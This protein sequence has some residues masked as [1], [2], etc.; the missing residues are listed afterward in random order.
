MDPA[1]EALVPPPDTPPGVPED[2]LC[3]HCGYPSG[4]S[5]SRI[6]PEC[7]WEATPAEIAA[8]ARRDAEVEGWTRQGAP[9]TKTRWLIVVAL[10][11]LGAGV[12]GREAGPAAYA[13][14]GLS[15]VVGLS[16]WMGGWCVLRSRP[17]RG[18]Y[19]RMVWQRK[20]WI[21][22]LPWLV[23]PLFVAAAVAVGLVDLWAGDERGAAYQTVVTSGFFLW[24]LASLGCFFAWWGV[25]LRAVNAGGYRAGTADALAFFAGLAITAGTV[26][27]GFLAGV[28][29]A[30]SVAQWLHIGVFVD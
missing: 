3:T 2:H 8:F 15:M 10:Y 26:M 16:W 22:H 20:L 9:R 25:R 18:A 5:G 12:I 6:C 11:S 17:D 28:L 13:L 7:G 4:R 14:L 19:L 27:L 24:L 23:A 21:L 1:L 30:L 29:S